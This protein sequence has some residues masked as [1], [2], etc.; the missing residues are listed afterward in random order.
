LPDERPVLARL[1]PEAEA[2]FTDILDWSEATFGQGAAL[3]YA[4]LIIQ[5]LRDLQADPARPGA[6]QRPE[7]PQGVFVY[8]LAGSR[9]RVAGDRVK[10]PR[11]FVLYRVL[12]GRVEVLRLL[13]DSR[14]L[15]RH[16]SAD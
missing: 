15:A 5:A 4:E 8:H 6:K 3:R 14:D 7:L 1:S 2:D 11:H 9:A 16:V 10:T 13:H 12:A